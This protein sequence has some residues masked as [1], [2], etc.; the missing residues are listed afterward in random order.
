MEYKVIVRTNNGLETMK[1]CGKSE[2]AVIRL[3][4]E[5]YDNYIKEGWIKS[6]KCL[7]IER[8]L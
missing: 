4:K 1:C 5:Y 7:K 3:V 2:N 6:Y 8:S